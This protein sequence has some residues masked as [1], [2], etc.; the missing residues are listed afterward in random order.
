MG[1]LTYR[2]LQASDL[3]QMFHTFN[4][5]FSD[6]LI[7]LQLSKDH[8]N[9]KFV[10]KLNISYPF[11]AGAFA[12]QKMVGF[13]LTSVNQYEGLSTAYNGGT[14]VIPSYRGRGITRNLYRFLKPLFRV[15]DV[16]QCV[17]EV[18]VNNEKAIQVY[19]KV[20]FDKTKYF[21]CFKVSKENFPQ[22]KTNKEVKIIKT[23]K[24]DWKDQ[25][26]FM[27]YIPSYLDTAAM[28]KK[29]IKNETVIEARLK[30]KLIGYAIYQPEIGRISHVAVERSS[31]KQGAGYCLIHHMIE[32]SETKQLSLIN[33]NSE[34][35]DLNNY[36]LSLGFNNEINQYEMRMLL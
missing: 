15:N 28:V 24:P 9:R 22:R 13:I 26:K 6:Y 10:S 11:S 32:N 21:K 18:L 12:G 35:V 7:P 23:S 8:F 33:L 17:L 25:I 16:K 3:N 19:Q 4:E 27:D 31:R 29:N 34:A 36:L 2:C 30:D 14:G 20:G 5:A 1:K